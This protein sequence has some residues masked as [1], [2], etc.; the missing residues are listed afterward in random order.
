MANDSSTGSRLAF[1]I[2]L[3]RLQEQLERSRALDSRLTN[4]FALSAAMVALLGSALLFSDLPEGSAVRSAVTAG[5][6]LFVANIVVSTSALLAGRWALAPNLDALLS[7][8]DQ[9]P[10]DEL[11]IEV[12]SSLVEVIESNERGLRRKALLVTGAVI[13]T[14]STAVTIA[15]AAILLSSQ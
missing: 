10:V 8:V 12:A 11:T 15:V 3:W 14:A 2:S 9:L 7:Y 6:A 4:A 5:A 1:E 13:L